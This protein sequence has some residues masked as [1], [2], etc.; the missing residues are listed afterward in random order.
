MTRRKKNPLAFCFPGY[1][2]CGPGCSGPGKPVNDV[3]T[4]CY[5]HDHC[6]GRGRPACD[7]DRE[8]LHCLKS[9][10]NPSTQK[11]RD[12]RTMYQFMKLKTA[13]TCPP[14]RRF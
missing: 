11:G 9:K 2:W 7:C 12:A 8:F 3:D 4:C 6:I 10:I 1:N 5:H 13:F 14:P